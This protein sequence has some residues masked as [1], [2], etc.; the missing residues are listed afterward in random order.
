MR[1]IAVGC[2][3]ICNCLNKIHL[4]LILGAISIISNSSFAQ[5]GE[6]TKPEYKFS[7]LD[8][9]LNNNR[10]ETILRDHLGYLWI[11]T[12]GGL[13][14]YDGANLSI[15]P[16]KTETSNPEWYIVFSLFEDS[17]Q[18]LWVSTNNGIYQYDRALD[19]FVRYDTVYSWNKI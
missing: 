7:P 9:D 8:L 15:Y 18:R 17:K 2:M 11:G 13:H 1:R 3:L 5:N 10:V 6:V 14:K 16:S 19:K 4:V 12:L